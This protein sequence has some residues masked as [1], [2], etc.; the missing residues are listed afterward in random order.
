ML[1]LKDFLPVASGIARFAHRIFVVAKSFINSAPAL[2]IFDKEVKLVKGRLVNKSI[3]KSELNGD[4][5]YSIGGIDQLVDW[6]D[7]TTTGIQSR[8]DA[9]NE[10]SFT[11]TFSTIL[12]VEEILCSFRLVLEDKTRDTEVIKIGVFRKVLSL[13]DAGDNFGLSQD[14]TSGPLNRE[15]IADL[16]LL[17]T[18]L[19]KFNL[20][21]IDPVLLAYVSLAAS[22]TLL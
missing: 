7:E 9:S 14:N 21:V 10:S 12:G 2:V 8:P 3:F 16:P 11:K 20:E 22:R 18:L 19:A 1:N 6:W 4:N 5:M 15:G 13:S 17:R